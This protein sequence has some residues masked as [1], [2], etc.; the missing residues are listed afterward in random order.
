M[1]NEERNGGRPADFVL[2]GAMR[3]GSTTLARGLSAHPGIFMPAKKELHFFDWNHD[4]GFDWYRSQFRGAASGQVAGEA[5]PIYMVYGDAMERLSRAL[6]EARL[7]AVLR[8]PTA[9]AYSHYWYNRMLGFEPLSFADALAA[10]PTRRP[11]T[12]DRRTFDYVER[13][14]YLGQ[15]QR[16]CELFP[17]DSLHVVVLE[18]LKRDPTSVYRDVFRFLGVD[19]SFEPPG[20]DAV[21]NA[22][23][24]YRS[25]VVSKLSRAMPAPIR[26][27]IRR[28]NRKN[29]RYP[30]MDPAVRRDLDEVFVE[31]NRS[32]SEWLGRELTGWG[33]AATPAHGAGRE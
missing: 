11:R 26:R 5:T 18:D 16:I 25:K 2:V 1:R 20:G 30:E 31:G 10:E 22:H 33:A 17:R 14:R 29:V 15:L 23:A 7:I 27:P 6:P 3:A 9:R 21:L 13:G 24:E 28:W 19:P 4:R 8:D 32:L 12:T